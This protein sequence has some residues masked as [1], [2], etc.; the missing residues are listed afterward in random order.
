MNHFEDWIDDGATEIERLIN[1]KSDI[2]DFIVQDK[3]D[4]KILQK[5]LAKIPIKKNEN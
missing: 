5:E 1:K 3:I 2:E 4:T